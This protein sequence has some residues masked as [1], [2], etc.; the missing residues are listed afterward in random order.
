MNF[1]FIIDCIVLIQHSVVVPI[2]VLLCFND[3]TKKHFLVLVFLYAIK[4]EELVYLKIFDFFV[5]KL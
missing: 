1:Y 2:M 5:K 4:L 3:L